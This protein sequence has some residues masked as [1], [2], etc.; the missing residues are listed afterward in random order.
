MEIKNEIVGI[1]DDEVGTAGE[2]AAAALAGI[3]MG[4]AALGVV[5]GSKWGF[6]KVATAVALRQ[7]QKKFEQY[8]NGLE[9]IEVED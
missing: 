1:E 4:I 9:E 5:E 7:E 8:Q 6:R 2:L 3:V